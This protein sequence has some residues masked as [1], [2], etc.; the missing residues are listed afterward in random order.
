MSIFRWAYDEEKCEGDFCCGDCD[1][2][3]KA[4]QKNEDEGEE[5][6]RAASD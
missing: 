1:Y 5:D 4:E 2:C 6:E 3:R